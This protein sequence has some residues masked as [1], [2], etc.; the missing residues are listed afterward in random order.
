MASTLEQL[1]VN[2]DV[3]TG[4][5]LAGG[6]LLG[7]MVELAKETPFSLEEVATGGKVL[8]AMGVAAGDVARTM[9]MLGDVSAGTSQPVS[10]LA[11]VF[12]EVQ[13]AGRLMSNELRQ[14]NMRGIPLLSE[15]SDML[16]VTKQEIRGMIEDG[17][18]TADMVEAAFERMTSAGG[19]FADLMGRQADT[20]SGK[21][22][23]LKDS[24]SLAGAKAVG[25]PG[26]SGTLGNFLR[27]AAE[28]AG[29]FVSGAASG[30]EAFQSEGFG[31]F[32]QQGQVRVALQQAKKRIADQQALNAAKGS[33]TI[34][35]ELSE[36]ELKA[37]ETQE[38]L[39]KSMADFVEQLQI[40]VDTF[41]MAS[42]AAKLYEL[43]RLGANEA[44]IEAARVLID[45]K[46]LKDEQAKAAERAKDEERKRELKDLEDFKK[47]SESVQT[48]SEKLKREF[49]E[50]SAKAS[51][52]RPFGLGGPDDVFT[53][54][55]A[56]IER[57]VQEQLP[58][59]VGTQSTA[60]IRAGSVDALRAQFTGRSVGEKAL[61]E[62]EK[63]TKEQEAMRDLLEDIRDRTTALSE[64][65]G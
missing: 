25:D 36:E 48:P 35:P 44:D 12:G 28:E 40:Q 7:Q 24:L 15:L 31:A 49:D 10:Q 14:F 56:D 26:T 37:I 47:L 22:E 62:A 33:A 30:A 39:N 55:F 4:S 32:T 2:M 43:K 3:M 52:M 1:R 34:E 23:K 53:R 5:P 63:Q 57:R 46:Q 50:L 13:Q 18:I 45:Q 65:P 11:Q 54:A 21:W 58:G 9:K 20:L 6:A 61:K 27:N 64:A 17:E 42:D 29:N 16:G 8:L 60:A 41:G 59:P 51:S 19:R 38:K